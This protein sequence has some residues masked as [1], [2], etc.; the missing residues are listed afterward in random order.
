MEMSIEGSSEPH[1]DLLWLRREVF[2][3]HNSCYVPLGKAC[4][5]ELFG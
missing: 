5:R 1:L 4:L 2:L 3:V